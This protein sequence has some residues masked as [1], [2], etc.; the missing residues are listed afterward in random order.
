MNR[1]LIAAAAIAMLAPTVALAAEPP[2][3]A[4]C[5]RIVSDYAYF[6]D[7]GDSQALGALFTEDG[8]LTIGGQ[9]MD[10]RAAI[11]A[12]HAQRAGRVSSRHFMANVRIDPVDRTTARGV[13][14]AMIFIAPGAPSATQ[15]VID[16]E[17]YTQ[18]GEY[19]D[20]FRLTPQGCQFTERTLVGVFRR[21]QPQGAPAAPAAGR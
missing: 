15:G 21:P 13:S 14:Y 18:I 9:T 8:K 17:G 10:G 11:V 3:L 19:H 1:H 2:S 12:G 7:H 6:W 16:L 20:Q 5:T 4:A